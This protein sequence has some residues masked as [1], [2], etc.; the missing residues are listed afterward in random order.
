MVMLIPPIISSFYSFVHNYSIKLL[1]DVLSEINNTPDFSHMALPI[2][3]FL[4]SNFTLEFIWRISHVAAWKS[5]PYV[6]RS[7]LLQAYD[8]VQHHSYQYFQNNFT[9]A[10]T[11]KIKGIL[12]GYDKLWAEIHHGLALVSLKIL[13]NLTFLMLVNIHLGLFLFGWSVCFF[14]IMYIFS[15]KLDRLA[16]AESESQHALIGQISDKIMNVISIFSFSAHKRE[17]DLLDKH[18]SNDY[19]PK[20]VKLYKYDFKLQIIGGILYC[21]KFTFILFY[22]IHLKLSGVISVGDFAFV[23][24]LTLALSEDM[25]RAT[26]SFQDFLKEIGDLKSAFSIVYVPQQNLDLP[27]AKPLHI[28]SPK[29]EFKHVN[30]SYADKEIVFKDLNLIISPGEKL[31]LVGHSGAGKSSMINLLMRYFTCDNGEILIDG[32]NINQVTQETLRQHIAV[33]PQDT[34]LFHRTLLDNLKYG[35]PEATENQIIEACK[36][37]YIHD[38]IMSLPDKYQTYA[39]ERGLK[40]SGGQRQRIAIAR[41]ILKDTPILLL[42]E[43]TSALDSQTEEIIQKSLTSLMM[44]K[45]KTVIAIAHRLST[46]KNMDRIIVLEKGTIVEQGTH[47]ELIQQPQSLY[48]KLWKLQ[49]VKN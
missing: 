3:L 22:T 17:L 16:F 41:A 32:Q 30:F 25:W 45:K 20:Q 13:V 37:A 26:M 2:A 1:L 8:Y 46:L 19:I 44:S 31:G 47:E 34:L 38:F 27:N 43:A 39:G 33:I 12:S 15:K 24:G 40:L 28:S 6:R 29:I 48:S 21:I 10:I 18:I 42:D 11:S 5:L 14:F 4:G 23:L 35:N 36:K 9:G 49:E 7:F